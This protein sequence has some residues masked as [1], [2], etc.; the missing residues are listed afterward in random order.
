MNN[1]VAKIESNQAVV[2][3][4]QMDLIKRTIAPTATPDELQL[5]FYD[6]QRRNVHPLDKLIH[7]S[8]RGGKYVPLTSIDFLRSR[9]ADSGQLG[10]IDDAIFSEGGSFPSQATVT[11]YRIV[12]GTR[13]PFTATAR[14]TEYCPQDEK[15][16]FM[17]K[18]MPYVMLSKCA[19]SLA[20]RK[21]FPQQLAGLYANEELDQATKPVSDVAQSIKT[22]PAPRQEA[23][24]PVAED[25]LN[26]D[27]LPTKPAEKTFEQVVDE[28]KKPVGKPNEGATWSSVI[29]PKFIKKYAGSTL[30]EIPEKDLRWWA[31]NYQ[32]K[33]FRGEIS[34]ADSDFRAALDLALNDLS[35][36]MP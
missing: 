33:P 18:K 31:S 35:D 32:P 1:A 2:S 15:Q 27:E 4:D 24:T 23:K 9:A 20:L 7:F 10:G 3:P 11:V 21:A 36:N 30:G 6:C 14:W 25:A 5:F 19:E 17:W 26:F 13:C 12:S 34:Q 22:P 29:V 16:A 8:K 28:P